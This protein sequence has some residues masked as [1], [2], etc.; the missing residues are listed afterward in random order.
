MGGK[1]DN[2][3]GYSNREHPFPRVERYEKDDIK[4]GDITSWGFVALK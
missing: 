4:E 1:F 2:K 3:K